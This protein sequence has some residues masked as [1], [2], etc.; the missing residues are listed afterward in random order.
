MGKL[1][2]WK[3]IVNIGRVCLL[4]TI[5]TAILMVYQFEAEPASWINKTVGD[6]QLL[7]SASGHIRPSATFSFSTGPIFFFAIAFAFTLSGYILK[8]YSKLL[9]AASTCSIILAT[10]VSGSRGLLLGLLVV[11]AIFLITTFNKPNLLSGGLKAVLIVAI[12]LGLTS[13]LEI[14]QTGVDVFTERV[15]IASE[16]EGGLTGFTGRVY[17]DFI[18]PFDLM[19]RAPLFGFGLGLGTNAGATLMY[20]K[21]EFILAEGEWSRMMLELGPLMGSIYLLLRCYLVCYLYKQAK[22]VVKFDNVLAVA[23]FGACALN[24]LSGQWGPPTGLGFAVFTGGLCLAASKF[25][26]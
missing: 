25:K 16:G 5:P 1:L 15:T 23:L 18:A 2:N 9:L 20:A 11:L 3:D 7:S 4:L 10:A 6:G 17:S 8:T 14:F 26:K 12:L 21:R 22:F 13:K 19:T 24:I